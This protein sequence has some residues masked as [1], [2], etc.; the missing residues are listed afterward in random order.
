MTRIIHKP[1]QALAKCYR[2]GELGHKANECPRRRQVN[3]A[4]YK[5]EDKVKIKTKPEDSDFTEKQGE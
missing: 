4:N 2:Y 5:D 1:S 3:M